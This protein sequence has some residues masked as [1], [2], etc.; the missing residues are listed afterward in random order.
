[1][2]VSFLA[3]TLVGATLL[4]TALF[5]STLAD[6][7]V[8]V[9]TGFATSAAKTLALKLAANTPATNTDKNLF[10]LTSPNPY[11]INFVQLADNS[12]SH[13]GKLVIA[14][15]ETNYTQS[16]LRQPYNS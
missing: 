4:A 14:A 16:N 11:K 13:L 9:A 12:G 8:G 15:R 1:M 7:A 10:M 3:A 5:A 2:P 6:E